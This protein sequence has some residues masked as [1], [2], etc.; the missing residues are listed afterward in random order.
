MAVHEATNEFRTSEG[1]APLE[2]NDDLAAISRN[3]SRNM[4]KNGFFDHNDHEGRSPGERADYFGYPDTAI[5]ENLYWLKIPSHWNSSDRVA[6]RAVSSWK[7]S[8]SHRSA[9]LTESKVVAGVGAYVTE[10]RKVYVTAM[11]ADR[12]GRIS[13]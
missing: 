2:Y 12:D 13:A 4:A 5:S 1:R 6:E 3:H 9:L 10:K 7:D 11:Y 8:A